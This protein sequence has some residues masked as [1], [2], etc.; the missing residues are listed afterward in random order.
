MKDLAKATI[1]G[2]AYDSSARDPP[3]RCHPETRLAVVER[4]QH[5]FADRNYNRSMMWLVGP[6]GVGKSAVMQTLAENASLSTSNIQLG[7]SLF[8][9]INGRDDGSKAITTLAYQLAVTHMPYHQYL[10]CLVLHDPELLHKSLA[11]QFDRFIVKPFT[12]LTEQ[13]NPGRQRFLIVID[14]VDECLGH[15]TQCELLGLVAHFCINHPKSDLVW[16]VAS[17]PEP[18]ITAFFSSD[19]VIPAYLKEELVVDS[20]QARMDVEKFLRDEF[21]R[22][23]KK[24]PTLVHLPRWPT[25]NDFLPIAAASDGLFAYGSTAIRFIYDSAYGNPA[26]RLRQLLEVIASVRVRG[27]KGK[28][29]P[30]ADL[31]ALYA[32][33]L[34]QVPQD[35]LSDTKKLFLLILKPHD[36]FSYM[37]T[38][39]D[40][41]GMS[42]DSVHGAVHQLHSVLNIPPGAA[43]KDRLITTFHKSFCDFLRDPSRSGLFPDIKREAEELNASCALRILREALTGMKTIFWSNTQVIVANLSIS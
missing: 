3:P 40:W 29:H 4:I 11:T 32:R 12:I 33:I 19:E 27:V 25:E 36:D 5:F 38:W 42:L 24:S 10:K 37:E 8:F 21:R 22:I 41:L 39:C 26:S 14:G 15:G 31:D 17:R 43:V 16:I 23:Q 6:A 1:P 13:A 28:L 2:A 20:D 35:I 34:S 18:H 9:S 30:M 7:A